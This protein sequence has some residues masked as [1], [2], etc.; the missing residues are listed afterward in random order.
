MKN[1]ANAENFFRVQSEAEQ[2]RGCPAEK[3]LKRVCFG[4]LAEPEI[5][6]IADH[7]DACEQCQSSLR[8]LEVNDTIL[9]FLRGAENSA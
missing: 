1:P 3:L 4:E 2:A 9:V 6:C 5:V 8:E 7:I